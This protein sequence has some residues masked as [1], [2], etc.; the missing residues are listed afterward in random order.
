MMKLLV[1]ILLA[2]EALL[3]GGV[4]SRI[5]AGNAAVL[6]LALNSVGL[7]AGARKLRKKPSCCR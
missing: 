7:I 2:A 4:L 1:Y 3:I 5:F 6:L